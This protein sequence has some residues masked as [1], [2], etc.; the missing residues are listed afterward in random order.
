MR[1]LK[2]YYM[3]YGL[4]K[5]SN[6]FGML[7]VGFTFMQYTMHYLNMLISSTK[8]LL[9]VWIMNLRVLP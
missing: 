7:R 6:L 8:F 4:A 1:G 2:M 9:W 5:A 3:R